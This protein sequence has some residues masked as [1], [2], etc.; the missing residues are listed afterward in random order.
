MQFVCFA[1]MA[2]MASFRG[3]GDHAQFHPMDSAIMRSFIRGLGEQLFYCSIPS[4]K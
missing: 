4:I 1:S 3:L 2:N